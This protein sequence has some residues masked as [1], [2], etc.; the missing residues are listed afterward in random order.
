MPRVGGNTGPL[1][2]PQANEPDRTSGATSNG[3]QGNSV[4]PDTVAAPDGM[5]RNR[6]IQATRTSRS[7]LISRAKSAPVPQRV[8][9]GP[10]CGLY[11]LG[12]VM[13]AWHIYDPDNQTALVQQKDQDGFGKQYTQSPTDN[14]FILDVARN[15][16]FTAVGEMFTAK[17]LAATAK[18]FG[19][20]AKTHHHATLDDLYQVI[21][22]GHPAI[23][24]FDVDYNGNPCASEGTRAHYAIIQGYFDDNGERYLIAR[25]GWG[26]QKD[27]LWSARDFE[28]SW[29]GLAKTDFYGAPG[30]G[31]IPSFPGTPEPRHMPHTSAGPGMVDIAD[32]L[33]AK[34]VEVVPAGAEFAEMK[35]A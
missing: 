32:S 14:R 1:A 28:D 3:V 27:H 18:E 30:D 11:A 6:D 15:K 25:H 20:R 19:Y 31:V 33:A 34:I 9:I 35:H 2:A 7:E 12:M 29:K 8:Q 26:V 5:S 22:A 13:D 17:D 23:V 16:G 10:T 24:A 21:D 4:G